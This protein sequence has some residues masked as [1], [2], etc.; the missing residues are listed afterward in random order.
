MKTQIK[1]TQ[2]SEKQ[3]NEED[4]VSVYSGKRDAC[5]CG[6]AG[7]YYYNPANQEYASLERGY[8]V[9]DDEL[10]MKMVRKILKLISESP[11]VEGHED[12][13]FTIYKGERQYTM[14][15]KESN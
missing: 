3:I 4:I 7:K 5:M 9:T 11:D 6:C 14:Y 2:E 12:Y 13:I 8:A 15:L 1:Y 10:N